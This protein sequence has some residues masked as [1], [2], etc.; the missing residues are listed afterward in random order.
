[1]KNDYDYDYDDAD[2]ED[3]D[4]EDD[5]DDMIFRYDYLCQLWQ[6]PSK[7]PAYLQVMDIAGLVKVCVCACARARVRDDL[8]MSVWRAGARPPCV[9]ACWCVSVRE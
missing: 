3:E 5:D 4:E 8:A 9:Q 7:Y 6:P 1:L 2:D